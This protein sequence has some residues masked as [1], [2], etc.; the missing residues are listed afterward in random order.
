MLNCCDVFL[1]QAVRI[2]N[3]CVCWIPQISPSLNAHSY[4]KVRKIL[5]V[6]CLTYSRGLRHNMVGIFL[7]FGAWTWIWALWVK[8]LFSRTA[9][10]CKDWLNR[11]VGEEVNV[12]VSSRVLLQTNTHVFM[13]GFRHKKKTKNMSLR[14]CNA[15]PYTDIFFHFLL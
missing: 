13:L 15:F 10:V 7:T 5:K 14:L 6:S 2:S 11:G 4:R 12:K 3:E 8:R 9:W 1:Q